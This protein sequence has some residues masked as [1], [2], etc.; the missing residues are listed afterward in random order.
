MSIRIG[1]FELILV[2]YSPELISAIMASTKQF[3]ITYH[4]I[5]SKSKD[6]CSI[7]KEYIDNVLRKTNSNDHKQ[8][9]FLHLSDSTNLNRAITRFGYNFIC[10]QIKDVLTKSTELFKIYLMLFLSKRVNAIP[11]VVLIVNSNLLDFEDHNILTYLINIMLINDNGNCNTWART[12]YKSVFR[13]IKNNYHKTLFNNTIIK[14][15]LTTPNSTKKLMCTTLNFM[16]ITQHEL[17]KATSQCMFKSKL[18]TE[19]LY[20]LIEIYD[21]SSDSIR[22][23]IHIAIAMGNMKIYRLLSNRKKKQS[24]LDAIINYTSR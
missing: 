22:Y 24:N 23:F 16:K 19:N 1:V 17:V 7:R 9:M 3:F 20:N 5:F 15:L 21:F 6:N 10:K 8:M 18:I 12:L 2:L 4:A 13:H 11:L 14:Q